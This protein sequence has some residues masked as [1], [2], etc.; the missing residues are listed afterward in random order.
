MFERTH[1]RRWVSSFR[2]AGQVSALLASILL[3]T[4][5]ADAEQVNLARFAV[6]STG[7]LC[8]R[9][10]CPWRGIRLVST[11]GA[12]TPAEIDWTGD[13]LP[14]VLATAEIRERL[15]QTWDDMGCLVVEG[16]FDRRTLAV[17]SILG[18][19]RQVLSNGKNQ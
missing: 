1:G 9:A 10:P 11:D 19:C 14:P 5:V 8:V 4:P 3:A 15:A 6:G 7:I 13:E 2:R 16:A 17:V 12:N 18:S